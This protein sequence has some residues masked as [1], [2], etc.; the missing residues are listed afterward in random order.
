MADVP[1]IIEPD[2]EELEAAEVLVEGSVGGRPYR[3]LLDTGAANT[4]I[5]LDAYTVGFDSLERSPTSGLFRQ[6][7]DDV[8]RVPVV[9]VGPITR[10]NITVAR[11]PAKAEHVANLIG[12]DV[13]KYFCL[14]FDL[15]EG[16]L[17]VDPSDD[18]KGGPAWHAL[19]MD[20]KSHPYVEVQFGHK[21]ASAVWDSGSSLT[22]VDATFINQHPAFFR[23]AGESTGTDSTGQVGATSLYVMSS[24][25]IGDST[26]PPHRVAAVDLAGVN[27]T[28]EMRMDLILGFS[29]LRHADWL[30]DFPHRRWAISRMRGL[31]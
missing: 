23:K 16:R 31:R 27:A 18:P 20:K 15:T 8:I 4:R 26:F 5:A 30:L 29:S 11:A 19:R 24:A 22:V 12:M 9:Q 1:L 6:G 2:A 17:T 21:Q 28:L 10:R 7:T 3:F 25:V 14:H 13:L